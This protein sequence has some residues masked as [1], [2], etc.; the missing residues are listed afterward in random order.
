MDSS[1]TTVALRSR[2]PLGGIL[3]GARLLA[4]SATLS[5]DQLD[6]LDV[7]ITSSQSLLNILNSVLDLSN[8]HELVLKVLG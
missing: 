3:A 1:L 4:G 8:P 2:R 7:I 5:Q 6:L